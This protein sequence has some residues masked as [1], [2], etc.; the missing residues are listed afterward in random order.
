MIELR[1]IIRGEEKCLQY[2][3]VPL[4]IGWSKG[5]DH[6]V[7]Q[8]TGPINLIAEKNWSKWEDVPVVDEFPPLYPRS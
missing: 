8:P 1:F 3:E 2:R 4:Q 5:D 7:I 6:P